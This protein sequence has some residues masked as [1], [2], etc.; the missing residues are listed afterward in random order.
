MPLSAGVCQ[1]TVTFQVTNNTNSA[2]FAAQ[3]AIAPNG[4]LTYTPAANAN[5]SATVTVRVIDNGGIAFGGIDTSASQTFTITVTPVNDVPSFTKGG[6]QGLAPLVLEDAAAQTVANWATNI[7]AG[8][9]NE[10]N[11]LCVPLSAAACQ[12]TVTFE[13]TNNSNTALFAA[14]PAIGPNGTLTYEP[15]PN[16]NG[17]ATVTVRAIDNGGTANGG[18]DTSASQTFTITVTPVNDVPSFTK[19]GDQG[20]APPVLEDAVA[21]TVANWATNISAGPPNETNGLCVPL[22]AAACQQTVTFEVTNNSNTALFAVQPA[23]APNGTLTYTPAPNANGSAT[24][25]VRVIDNGGVA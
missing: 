1:Q 14:P 6:D 15:A 21:Q 11:G 18:I 23:I 9:P 10:T 19:G 12:Q 7:S 25:T 17:T 24:V 3:P 2:L 22:S 16:A 13:V 8:P 4:T 5:G 20:L